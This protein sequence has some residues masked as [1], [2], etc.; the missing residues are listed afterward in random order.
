M[1]YVLPPALP[2]RPQCRAGP[3]AF[4]PVAGALEAARLKKQKPVPHNKKAVRM[5][6]A[7]LRR[8]LPARAARPTLPGPA[9]HLRRLP[10][11]P[12]RPRCACPAPLRLRRSPARL[13]CPPMP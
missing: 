9:D 13:P 3:G 5:R 2:A 11:N 6:R 8:P 10:G 4:T 7:A 1:T 12:A